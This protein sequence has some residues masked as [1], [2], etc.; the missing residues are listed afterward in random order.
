MKTTVD[1]PSDLI[2]ALKLT[3]LRRN[4]KLGV[5]VAQCLASALAAPQTIAGLRHAKPM[6]SVVSQ[7]AAA[8]S[9]GNLI[10]DKVRID[11][12]GLPSIRCVPHAPASRMSLQALL[13]LEQ[14]SQLEEDAQRAGRPV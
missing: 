7:W 1:L 2:L 10:S 14:Q 5:T 6:S 11:A 4:Q 12:D 8:E 13:A 9:G 3:A